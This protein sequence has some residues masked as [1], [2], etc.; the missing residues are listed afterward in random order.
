MDSSVS[1]TA[2]WAGRILKIL[3][4]LFLVFDSTMKII[5]HST[6]VEGTKQFGLPDASVRFLGIYLFVIT[7]LYIVPK[8][9]IA[10]VLL[11]IA[12][13]GSATA[14]MYQHQPQGWGF[15]FPVVFAILIVTA[16]HLQNA[17]FRNILHLNP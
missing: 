3:L 12:Y 15:L 11:L 5:R 10:G 4:C 16:E 1:T 8:T 17:S 13:L 2:L 9:T 14:I 6:S 7:I